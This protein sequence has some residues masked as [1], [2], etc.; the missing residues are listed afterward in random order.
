MGCSFAFETDLRP[1]ADRLLN[2]TTDSDRILWQA[3]SSNAR[4]ADWRGLTDDRFWIMLREEDF[5]VVHLAEKVH[6]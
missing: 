2:M 6:P 4:P 1:K 3:F 5:L